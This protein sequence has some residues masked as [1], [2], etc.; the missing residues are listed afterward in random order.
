M[1]K[2]DISDKELDSLFD[3]LTESVR[4]PKEKYGAQ[5]S[6]PQLQGRLSSKN[7]R[8]VPFLKY[9]AAASVAIILMLSTYF[10][11]D[12]RHTPEMIT[13]ITNDSTKEVVLPDGSHVV[14]NHYSRLQYPSEFNRQDRIVILSGEACF[15][16]AKKKEHPFSVHSGDICVTVLGTQFNVQSYSNDPCIKTTLIK[17]KVA[18]SPLDKVKI[19]ILNP[20]ETAYFSKQTGEIYKEANENAMNEIAWKEGKLIFENKPLAEITTD[21]SNYFNVQIKID[22]QYLQTYKMTAR[23]EQNENIEEILNILQASADFNWKRER[24]TIIITPNN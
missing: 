14:L 2:K 8:K 12:N 24:N 16:I 3:Q 7:P 4:G 9:I 15:D 18:I 23:F 22:N 13:V 17:G 19:T 5:N 11:L 21:L 20:N 1:R 10:L 6:Y